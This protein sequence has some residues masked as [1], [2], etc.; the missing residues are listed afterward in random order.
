MYFIISAFFVKGNTR[1]FFSSLLILS[2]A[3]TIEIKTMQIN[4]RICSPFK[5]M[6]E[7]IINIRALT[8]Q[9]SLSHQCIA[10]DIVFLQRELEKILLR[11]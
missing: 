2:S 3:N 10:P 9:N 5:T 6:Y 4:N 8:P 1:T 7:L 11:M